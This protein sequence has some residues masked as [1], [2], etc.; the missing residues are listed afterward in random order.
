MTNP[1]ETWS[2]SPTSPAR[3]LATIIPDDGADL[4]EPAKALRIWNP[5]ENSATVS[6]LP[7]SAADG[8][9]P[10]VLL[11][12]PGLTVEPLMVRRV[13]ATGTTDGLTLHAYLR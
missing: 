3:L 1:Y 9:P 6:L 10:V 12:P 11:V 5:S 7:L 2:A 8:D 4:S 13:L